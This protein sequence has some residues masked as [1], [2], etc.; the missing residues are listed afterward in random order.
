[1][2]FEAAGHC[3]ECNSEDLPVIYTKHTGICEECLE[4]ALLM[5]RRKGK[6]YD[7]VDC[8]ETLHQSPPFPC[9]REGAK[10]GIA[11]REQIAAKAFNR[12]REEE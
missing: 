12:A 6:Q 3:W 2:E 4:K 7:T 8:G 9:G 1:M 10:V 11:I 5:I